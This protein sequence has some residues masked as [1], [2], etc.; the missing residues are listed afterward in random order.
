MSSRR[1]LMALV[2]AGALLFASC[3]SEQQGSRRVQNAANT[4]AVC[5]N[6]ETLWVSNEGAYNGHLKHGDPAGPC[7][8]ATTTTAATT[9]TLPATTTTAAATTTL[10]AT[11]TTVR[12]TTT[13][14]RATTTTVRTGTTRTR[15]GRS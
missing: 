10:P 4:F 9:T 5:H 7:A 8:D 3:G 14:V 13:T 1:E 11:T 2:I 6:G 12:A 15:T